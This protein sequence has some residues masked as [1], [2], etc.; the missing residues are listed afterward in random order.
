MSNCIW[1]WASLSVP[2]VGGE[3]G[4]VISEQ[5]VGVATKGTSADG[6]IKASRVVGGGSLDTV[7][8]FDVADVEVTSAI[9]LVNLVLLNEP[10]VE[11]F[12]DINFVIYEIY[13]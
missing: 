5:V 6:D 7:A 13:A 11:G 9:S 8:A 2:L 1:G 12:V 4:D 3:Y 10:V